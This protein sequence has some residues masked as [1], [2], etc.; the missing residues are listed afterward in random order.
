[1]SY[2]D[3]T[4][5]SAVG[6]VGPNHQLVPFFAATTP[7]AIAAAKKKAKKKAREEI[8][9]L[10]DR[11]K[12]KTELREI[13]KILTDLNTAKQEKAAKKAKEKEDELERKNRETDGHIRGRRGAS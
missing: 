4:I 6:T 12:T 7:E 3:S 1:M 8:K 13:K 5:L 10:I 9:V 2:E 11:L